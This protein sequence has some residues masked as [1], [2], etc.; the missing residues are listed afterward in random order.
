MFIS[1]TVAVANTLDAGACTGADIRI[2]AIP[3]VIVIVIVIIK[4]VRAFTVCVKQTLNT[5]SSSW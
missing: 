3:V 2:I 4:V 1:I 5:F